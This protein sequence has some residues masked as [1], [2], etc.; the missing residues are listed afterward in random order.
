MMSGVSC[1]QSVFYNGVYQPTYSA[2]CGGLIPGYTGC[3]TGFEPR[4][5]N[6]FWDGSMPGN[7]QAQF[8]CF[9]Q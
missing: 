4:M 1:G 5:Y 9:K 7:Y 2:Q 8:A 6:A 3:P